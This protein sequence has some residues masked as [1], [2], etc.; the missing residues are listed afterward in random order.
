[1]IF[2]SQYINT[3][4]M[5]LITNG[6]FSRGVGRFIPEELMGDYTDFTNDWYLNVGP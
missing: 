5:L 6:S 3:G 2:V 1:M 4:L